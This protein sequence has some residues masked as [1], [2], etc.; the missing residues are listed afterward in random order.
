MT[1]RKAAEEEKFSRVLINAEKRNF[2]SLSSRAASQ[3]PIHWFFSLPS[4]VI[5]NHLKNNQLASAQT[6]FILLLICTPAEQ[7][8]AKTF[9]S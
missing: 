2:F 1:R 4:T 8:R 3:K 7:G 9:H 6:L 5:G